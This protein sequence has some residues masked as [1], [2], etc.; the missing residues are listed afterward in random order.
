ML[1][2]ALSINRS[3]EDLRVVGG[4]REEAVRSL[5]KTLSN[6]SFTG[7][8]V[9]S[10]G[11]KGRGE[12]MVGEGKREGREGKGRVGRRGEGRRG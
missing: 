5:Q 3:L 7:A 11:L 12:I 1:A 8:S 2:A 6:I 10:G 9:R 4:G